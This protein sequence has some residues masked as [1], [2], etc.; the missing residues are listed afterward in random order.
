MK[1]PPWASLL[2]LTVGLTAATETPAATKPAGVRFRDAMIELNLADPGYAWHGYH[3][4]IVCADWDQDGDVDLLVIT[5]LHEK[6]PLGKQ[7]RFYVN[8]LTETGKLAF[9]DRTEKLM[10]GGIQKQI[11]ADSA[12]FFFDVDADG[13]LDLCVISDE[14]RPRTFLRKNGR[15]EVQKWGFSSQ[16]CRV[17]DAD[18]D[19]DLDVVGTDRGWLYRNDG[20]GRFTRSRYKPEPSGHMPRDKVLPTPPGIQGDDEVRQR[21]AA[22]GHVYYAWHRLD[23]N[24]DGRGDYWLQLSKGYGFKLIRVY[25]S[26][27]AGYKDITKQTGLPTGVR[28]RFVPLRPGA[29]LD[30]IAA[31]K[32]GAG[33]YLA[34]GKGRFTPAGK[35]DA[36][37]IF[38]TVIGGCYAAPQVLVDFDND[39]QVDIVTYQPRV[40]AASAVLGAL[41]EGRFATVLRTRARSGQCVADFN[42]DGL[43][44]VVAS[45]QTRGLHVWLNVTKPAGHWLQVVVRGLKQ[46]PFAVGSVVEAFRSGG[47]QRP[48]PPLAQATAP[49]NGL[50]VHLGL[51]NHAVVDLRIRFADGSTREVK[52]VKADRKITVDAGAKPERSTALP[53]LDKMRSRR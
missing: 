49:R 1:A 30:A 18:A 34:D 17:F 32:H 46:N 23:L 52:D 2:L 37:T 4:A 24:G 10:P 43:I 28:M 22:S 25:A 41:G 3:D 29:P 20:N 15:F 42:N 7:G 5:S 8:R 45:E 50:P 6:G 27:E 38:G 11:F 16:S 21:A 36:S 12:P 13:D 39:G 44:D 47:S 53:P 26:T 31:G 19:G 9:E 51:G 40:G 33:I 35:S 14:I 48:N